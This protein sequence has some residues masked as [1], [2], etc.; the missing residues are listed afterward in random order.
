MHS[1]CLGLTQKQVTAIRLN[2][3]PLKY[4]CASLCDSLG[5]LVG[6]KSVLGMTFSILDNIVGQLLAEFCTKSLIY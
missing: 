6:D 1:H 5:V 2:D 3:F 4:P